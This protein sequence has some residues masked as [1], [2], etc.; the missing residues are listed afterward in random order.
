MAAQLLR[1]IRPRTPDFVF[2]VMPFGDLASFV[3]RAGVHGADADTPSSLTAPQ[4]DSIITGEG[5]VAEAVAVLEAFEDNY[6]DF[7]SG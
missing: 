6:A 1:T 7:D 2:T 3:A 5:E 4:D